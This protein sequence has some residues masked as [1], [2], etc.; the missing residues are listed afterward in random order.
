MYSGS[1]DNR[2]RANCVSGF[3]SASRIPVCRFYDAM[4]NPASSFPPYQAML[5]S[6]VK[7]LKPCSRSGGYVFLRPVPWSRLSHYS[8]SDSKHSQG[9]FVVLQR[10]QKCLSPSGTRRKNTWILYLRGIL[11]DCFIAKF[12][13]RGGIESHVSCSHRHL[14]DILGRLRI[15]SS[16]AICLSV[17]LRTVFCC[18]SPSLAHL[19][20]VLHLWSIRIEIVSL[21]SSNRVSGWMNRVVEFPHT[22]RGPLSGHTNI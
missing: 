18:L 8:Y 19:L 11:Y 16:L 20:L 22:Y 10:C 21:V 6:H 2:F 13:F 7:S 5:K 12:Y 1:Q 17:S 3:S 4:Q 14:S 9:N 15:V